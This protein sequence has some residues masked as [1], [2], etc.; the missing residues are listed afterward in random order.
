MPT[1]SSMCPV[2]YE[3]YS[4]ENPAKGPGGECPHSMCE[5]CCIRTAEFM[6]PPFQC[7]ECRRDIT[8]WLVSN[9]PQPPH[10][11]LTLEAAVAFANEFGIA[12]PSLATLTSQLEEYNRT[13][14]ADVARRFAESNAR[15]QAVDDRYRARLAEISADI[16]T[17]EARG[18]ANL[19]AIRERFAA[20]L[21]EIGHS[22]P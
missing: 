19:D 16:D 8:D 13:L 9:F 17:F 15:M 1:S 4:P 18:R 11:V 14:T 2:C 10:T 12:L 21:A 5:A 22:L 20:R 6:H 7:P 3:S